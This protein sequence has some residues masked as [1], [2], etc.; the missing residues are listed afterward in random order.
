MKPTNKCIKRHEIVKKFH[1]QNVTFF[2]IRDVLDK[3]LYASLIKI[4]GTGVNQTNKCICG[5]WMVR[6]SRLL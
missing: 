4:D 5:L 1:V 6:L 3:N 2:P